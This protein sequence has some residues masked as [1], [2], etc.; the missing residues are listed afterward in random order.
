MVG[1]GAGTVSLAVKVT[2]EDG[3]ELS[4]AYLVR[5]GGWTEEQYLREASETRIVEFEDGEVIVHS[6]AGRR[7]QR[8]IRFLTMVLQG[9][10]GRR[11]LGEILNG[12]AVVRLRSGLYYEPDIFFIPVH[13]LHESGE[14]F[15]SGVPALIVEIVSASSRSHDLR[16]KASAYRD[17]GVPE[18]WTIDPDRAVLTRHLLPPDPQAP[19]R[20]SEH[21]GGRLESQTV[22]GFWV[23]VSWLWQDPLPDEL[24]CLEQILAA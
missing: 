16:T 8:L 15:F 11:R 19:Y 1:E 14:D 18:Y 23:D 13:Q 21:T 9:F 7:H 4:A 2:M 22:P 10:V 17:R 20:A 5:F 6:P 24:R 12:P 3:A